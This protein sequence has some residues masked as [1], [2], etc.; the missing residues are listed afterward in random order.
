MLSTT[1]PRVALVGKIGPAFGA[2]VTIEH[3]GRKLTTGATPELV[4]RVAPMS[5]LTLLSEL[6]ITDTEG[7]L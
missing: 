3:A 6:L 7:A 4:A 2:V 1:A 5:P